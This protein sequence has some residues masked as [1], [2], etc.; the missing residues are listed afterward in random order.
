MKKL[1]LT[2]STDNMTNNPINSF[3]KTIGDIDSEVVFVTKAAPK[4]DVEGLFFNMLMSLADVSFL[5]NVEELADRM[6]KEH[7]GIV[8]TIVSYLQRVSKEEELN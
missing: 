1:F 3:I 7:S 5:D 2:L 8:T 4:N 6:P